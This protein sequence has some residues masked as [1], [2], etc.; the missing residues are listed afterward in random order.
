MVAVDSS[1]LIAY[2]GGQLD[3]ESRTLDSLLT[4][5]QI[6]LPPPV[7][8]E[9]LSEPGLPIELA[10]FFRGLP[11]LALSDGYWERCGL[12]RAQ[13]LERGLKAR[14][15][16]ALIAQT[17]IDHDVSLLTRDADFHHFV[18]FGLRLFRP[19]G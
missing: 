12:L 14:L 4:A 8:A 9:V 11:L 19:L 10:T 13:L 16:D 3:L 15:A 18:R 17:C 5:K 6:V 1:S 2:T 7:L